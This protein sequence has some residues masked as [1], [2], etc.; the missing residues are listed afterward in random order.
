M[1]YASITTDIST[2][3]ENFEK[4][5]SG[6]SLKNINYIDININQFNPL[7]R[8]SYINLPFDI[9]NKQAIINVQNY[10]NQCLK[11][12]VLSALHPPV[13]NAYRVDHY[14]RFEDELFFNNI[15]FPMKIKDITKFE[16]LNNISINVF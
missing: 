2:K 6:W 12:A 15:P 9:A 16:K 14:K 3:F 4:K 8:S 1:I 5:H 11:W 13:H 7:R 10:D